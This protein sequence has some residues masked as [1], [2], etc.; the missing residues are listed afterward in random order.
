MRP[1]IVLLPLIALVVAGVAVGGA[2]LLSE[3]DEGDPLTVEGTT[4]G[5]PAQTPVS[6]RPQLEPQQSVCQGLLHV[7]PSG[8]PRDFP[9]EYTQ[10][11]EVLGFSIV[12]GPDVPVE[13]IDAAAATIEDVFRDEALREPLV[14]VGAYIAIADRGQQPQDLPEFECLAEELGQRYT[15]LCGIADRADYPV[16]AVS[17]SDLLGEGDGPCGGLN[18]LYHELGHFVHGWVISPAD[19][20]D[21]RVLYQGAIDSDRYRGD[22][23]ALTSPNEYFAEG[24]QAYFHTNDRDPASARWLLVNDPG[25]YALMES[26]YGP[27]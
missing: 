2:M 17:A 15:H 22:S 4:T 21:V 25:L 7:P 16:I 13:A 12:A 19:Y 18:I 27:R 24:T 9:D 3:R 1:F 23:Y 6:T 20:I 11:R 26:I 14:D 5:T 10:I 8:T